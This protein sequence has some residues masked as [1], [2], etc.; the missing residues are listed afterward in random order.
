MAT[1]GSYISEVTEE[2]FMPSVEML[3]MKVSPL[4]R[5][6]FKDSRGVTNDPSLGRDWKFIKHFGLGL[7]GATE[8]AP[9]AGGDM[10]DVGTAVGYRA[11]SQMQTWPSAS[12]STMTS[13]TS[14]SVT[15][16]RMRVAMYIPLDLL[17]AAQMRASIE[18]QASRIIEGTAKR[19]AYDKANAFLAGTPAA[20]RVGTLGSFTKVG[21]EN[22]TSTPVS[23][24]LASGSSI[25]RF[26]SGMRCDL[27][28][29]TAPGVRIN[30]DP[31]FVDVCHPFI[32][33][34]AA[35]A[36]TDGGGTI[37][38]SHLGAGSTTLTDGQTYDI[39]LRNCGRE[40][41]A[42]ST[43]MPTSLE[44]IIVASGNIADWGISATTYP[45]LASLV[46]DLSGAVLTESILLKFIAHYY[47][48]RGGANMFDSLWSTA[49]VW[50]AYFNNKDA[51]FAIERN[52]ALLNVKDGVAEG[53]S[54]SLYGQTFAFRSDPLLPTGSVWGLKIGDRNWQMKTPPRIRDSK[55]HKLFDYSIEWLTPLMNGGGDIWEGHKKVG[56]ADAGVATDVL[57]A[58]GECCYEICPDE[59]IPGL[60]LTNAAEYY[61]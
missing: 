57:E 56:G 61:G 18:D 2:V 6:F 29:S 45:D 4:F 5:Y 13:Y 31:V 33:A 46:S 52:G 7:S 35:T 21:T 34:D 30:T 59:V 32:K 8:F 22:I 28:N 25:R 11:P 39:T 17:R 49:G 26:A 1:L 60:K 15:L 20:G 42:G 58:L 23:V 24:D 14:R 44:S 10:A 43:H 55:T 38:L 16:K 37:K 53:A 47:Q 41:G 19:V 3:T 9:M 50:A 12:E 27:Y 40:A 51:Q 54:Y 36:V 48:K